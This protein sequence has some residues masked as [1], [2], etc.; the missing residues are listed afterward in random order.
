MDPRTWPDVWQLV[1][2]LENGSESEMDPDWFETNTERYNG[3]DD[4]YAGQ[5]SIYLARKAKL[6]L[7]AFFSG[8]SRIPPIQDS[9]S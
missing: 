1:Y 3:T 2:Q 5:I 7:R 8:I 9:K 6:F 4:K